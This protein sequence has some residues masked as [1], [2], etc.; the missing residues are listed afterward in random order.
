MACKGGNKDDGRVVGE[1][2]VAFGTKVLERKGKGD[3][4]DERT[5]VEA[6]SRDGEVDV[7]GV[8]C[9]LDIG[10]LRYLIHKKATIASHVW[11]T[12]GGLRSIRKDLCTCVGS[13][14]IIFN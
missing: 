6:L 3:G 13:G 7:D 10:P 9:Y 12:I 11:N 14:L 4:K 2:K 5:S 8:E 1:G